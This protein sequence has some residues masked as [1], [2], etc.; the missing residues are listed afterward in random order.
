MVS[1]GSP[2]PSTSG[3]IWKIQMGMVLSAL[4][5]LGTLISTGR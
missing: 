3:V 5:T 2:S 4:V 1:C